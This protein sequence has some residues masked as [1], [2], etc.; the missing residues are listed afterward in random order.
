[1]KLLKRWI[2]LAVV[3]AMLLG[4]ACAQTLEQGAKG[5]AVERLQQ[6]L[7][8][9]GFLSI[10]P[11]GDY[12]AKTAEAVA[13]FQAYFLEAGYALEQSG[14]ADEATQALLFDDGVADRIYALEEGDDNGYVRRAQR[15]LIELGYLE[16][17]ADGVYGA[18]T[19]DAI[20]AFQQMLIDNGVAGV[21]VTGEADET[22]L[23]YLYSELLGFRINTPKF[24]NAHNAAQLQ[25]GNLYATAAALIDA[26]SGQMLF[27]K[28]AYQKVYPASTTKIMTLLLAL[29]YEPYDSI[30]TVPASAGE[31][32]ADSSRVPISVGEQLPYEDLLYGL[33]IRSGNDAANALATLNSGSVEAF[34]ERMNQTAAQLG[35]G[36]THYDNPHG[37]HSAQHYTTAADMA[38]LLRACLQNDRF[39]EVFHTHSHQMA[40]TNQRAA[41]T[42]QCSYAIFD[43]ASKYYDQD[44]LGGKTGF[45]S[46]AGYCFVCEAERDGVHLIAAVFDSGS[47]GTCRWTDVQRLF[48]YGFAVKGV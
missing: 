11:D 16:G 23:E 38:Q 31:V 21:T 13:E 25:E 33:M 9:L 40:Q 14:V 26:D 4:C 22:T 39:Q 44:A 42:I 20:E 19:A 24:Y 18:K 8:Y 47:N 36:S 5:E 35:L 1:M 32:P 29:E 17:S 2:A 3:V 28:N 37:Y 7:Y 15:R 6:R 34:V 12:G 27:G 41:R 45:T 30:V 46:A 10:S 43:S 48:D